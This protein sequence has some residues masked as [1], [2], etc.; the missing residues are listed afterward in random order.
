MEEWMKEG[1]HIHM[2]S[3][4]RRRHYLGSTMASC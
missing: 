1:C 4:E 3:L 2:D